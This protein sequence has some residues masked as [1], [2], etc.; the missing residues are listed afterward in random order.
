MVSYFKFFIHFVLTTVTIN[1]EFHSYV[2]IHSSIGF[3]II[4][5]SSSYYYPVHVSD[6]ACTGDENT[7]WDCPYTNINSQSC[8]RYDDAAVVCQS[9]LSLLKIITRRNL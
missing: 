1:C 5:I 7:I 2:H 3:N 6:L 9:K 8:G 4:S